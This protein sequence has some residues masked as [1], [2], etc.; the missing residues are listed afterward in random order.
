MGLEISAKVDP[1]FIPQF[2]LDINTNTEKRGIYVVNST[3]SNGS[4]T[5]DAKFGIY[6]GATGGGTAHNY[7]GAFDAYGYWELEI[8]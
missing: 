1:A 2:A 3:P 6:A 8:W 4:S 7:G 5:G